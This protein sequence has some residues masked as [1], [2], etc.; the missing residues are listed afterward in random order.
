MSFSYWEEGTCVT[1]REVSLEPLPCHN[2]HKATVSKSKTWLLWL[3][4]RRDA[5]GGGGGCLWF[6]ADSQMRVPELLGILFF[7]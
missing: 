6:V 2:Q 7:K 3:G 5:A 4:R 1:K